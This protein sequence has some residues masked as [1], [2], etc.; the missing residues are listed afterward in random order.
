MHGNYWDE[1]MQDNWRF[2]K[3]TNSIDD[4]LWEKLQKY[5]KIRKNFELIVKSRLHWMQQ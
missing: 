1:I 2:K 3:Q 5:R 4:L